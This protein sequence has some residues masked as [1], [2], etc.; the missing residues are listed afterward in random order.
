MNPQRV[1][2]VPPDRP[3]ALIANGVVKLTDR[4]FATWRSAL[5]SGRK[6]GSSVISAR[7]LIRLRSRLLS[8]YTLSLMRRRFASRGSKVDAKP[9]AHSPSRLRFDHPL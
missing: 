5:F 7:S 4:E 1:Q 6:P 9:E 2:S 3:L 8:A